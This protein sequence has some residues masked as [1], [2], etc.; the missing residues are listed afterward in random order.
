MKDLK[1]YRWKITGQTQVA[2]D[3]ILND[4][5]FM[6]NTIYYKVQENSADVEL[7]FWERNG[8]FKH[9][10]I[11]PFSITESNERLD[12]TWISLVINTIFPNS[13]QI[14]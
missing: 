7:L 9:S 10:R 12:K 14:V 13:E 11:Y 3:L 5:E 4:P 1:D 6:C 8:L 2:P